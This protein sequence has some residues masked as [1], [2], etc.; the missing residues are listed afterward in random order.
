M[1]GPAVS[2][3]LDEVSGINVNVSTS[4]VLIVLE[5]LAFGTSLVHQQLSNLLTITRRILAA[6]IPILRRI[7][8]CTTLFEHG[9][10]YTDRIR[11]AALICVWCPRSRYFSQYASSCTCSL[12]LTLGLI[13][14]A[15][16]QTRGS[17]VHSKPA[18]SLAW[19]TQ[20]QTPLPMPFVGF[21]TSLY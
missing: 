14:T 12:Q 7:H 6:I 5:S 2:V 9:E 19:Q 13:S 17:P 11:S 4:L 21:R 18:P 3:A 1:S 15:S 20:P 8:V 16:S 10:H